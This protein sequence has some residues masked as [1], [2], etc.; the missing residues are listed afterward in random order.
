MTVDAKPTL[1]IVEDD[2]DIMEMLTAFFR[3]QG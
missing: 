2:L 3:V 1:L